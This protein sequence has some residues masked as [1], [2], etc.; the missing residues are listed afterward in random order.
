MNN[1]TGKGWFETNME[2]VSRLQ[3]IL[4]IIF[5]IL[6]FILCILSIAFRAD[7]WFKDEWSSFILG[8]FVPYM[9]SSCLTAVIFL[10]QSGRDG[11][12]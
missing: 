9:V 5:T 6:G 2:E 4:F 8:T 3:Q 1:A 7:M 10:R 12:R 11:L